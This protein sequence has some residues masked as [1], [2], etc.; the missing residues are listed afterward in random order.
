MQEWNMRSL[1]WNLARLGLPGLMLAVS[2]MLA[3]PAAQAVILQDGDWQVEIDPNSADG[4]K[5]WQDPL[6]INHANQVGY[7]LGGESEPRVPISDLGTP[8]T[9]IVDSDGDG[10]NDSLNSRYSVPGFM[11]NVNQRLSDGGQVFGSFPGEELFVSTLTSVITLTNDSDSTELLDLFLYTDMELLG[12]P[13]DIELGSFFGNGGSTGPEDLRI[14]QIDEANDDFAAFYEADLDPL[15]SVLIAEEGDPPLVLFSDDDSFLAFLSNA[16]DEPGGQPG[17]ISDGDLSALV[18]IALELAPG[19]SFQIV[20]NQ[21]LFTPV[22]EPGT[23]AL[24][25][26]GMLALAISGRRRRV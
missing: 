1:G 8:T 14:I 26:T 5:R 17:G 21:S 23:A 4:L 20:H 25:G 11:V 10:D 19:E 2:G 9:T 6:G 22:P 13:V 24:L 18:G 7:W 3:A 15:I 12:T 16:T